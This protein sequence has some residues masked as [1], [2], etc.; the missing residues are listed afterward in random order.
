MLK[1]PYL[2]FEYLRTTDKS[3]MKFNLGGFHETLLIRFNFGLEWTVLVTISHEYLQ[4]FLCTSVRTLVT[5][6]CF[7]AGIRICHL[8]FCVPATEIWL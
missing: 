3:L 7:A 4:T 5:Y 2:W 6:P 1:F 8:M